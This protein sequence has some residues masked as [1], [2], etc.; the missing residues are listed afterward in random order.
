[1]YIPMCTPAWFRIDSSLVD[2]CMHAY[3]PRPHPSLRE[4]EGGVWARDYTRTRYTATVNFGLRWEI[5]F[6]F[7]V[8]T[9]LAY[10]N[11]IVP[12]VAQHPRNCV[13]AHKPIQIQHA[14][15]KRNF[16]TQPKFTVY[17]HT[18]MRCGLNSNLSGHFSK[19][20]CSFFGTWYFKWVLFSGVQKRALRW[21]LRTGWRLSST[22]QRLP[23]L[24]LKKKGK[25]V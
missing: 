18:R 11:S 17:N 14:K 3:V 10:T 20:A 9:Q 4:G 5:A 8:R 22:I 24:I 16:S 19:L 2:T 1:M 23:L 12:A 21:L 6:A 7:C 25:S 13:L 15:R